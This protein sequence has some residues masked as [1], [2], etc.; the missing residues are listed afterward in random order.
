MKAIQ[1]LPKE[2]EVSLAKPQD[3]SF[4]NVEQL[5]KIL[6]EEQARFQSAQSFPIENFNDFIADQFKSRFTGKS[7]LLQSFLKGLKNVAKEDK[8]EAGAV[9]NA[10]K[11]EI[12]QQTADILKKYSDFKE[13]QK[14]NAEAVDLS[15]PLPKVRQGTRHPV[16]AVLNTLIRSMRKLG[17]TIVD[18]PEVDRDYYNFETLNI[19]A[20]HPSREDQDTFY[21][22]AEWVLRTQTSNA[23]AH[24]MLERELPIK[25][26]SPGFVYRSDLDLT[27]TPCFHQ[28]EALVVDKDINMG[29]MRYSIEAF[30]SEVFGRPVKTR[31]RSN[32]FPFT[33][34]SAEVDVQCQ[35]CMGKGC[36]T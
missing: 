4:E 11:K 17:Y 28:I 9:I 18:G 1:E 24:T 35:T 33:E 32:Y 29:H 36:R 20:E 30:L 21:L 27:H 14:L 23:Q 22:A 31:F 15:L 5:K 7:S 2:L 10:V 19:P 8:K 25:V 12:E 26:A 13:T 3:I 16:T 6:A 34:P